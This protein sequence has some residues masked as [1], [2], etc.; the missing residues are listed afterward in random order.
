MTNLK[1]RIK[2]LKRFMVPSIP[3][4]IKTPKTNELVGLLEDLAEEVDEL[5]LRVNELLEAQL[6][7]EGEEEDVTE[8]EELQS[9]YITLLSSTPED[10]ATGV[11]STDTITLMFSGA[12]SFAHGHITVSGSSVDNEEVSLFPEGELVITLTEPIPEEGQLV[13]VTIGVDALPI[14]E[15]IVIT[16]T[17]AEAS[18]EEESEEEAV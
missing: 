17:M 7:D 3:H 9:S 10:G 5:V 1:D 4:A 14:E 6:G 11:E 18:E 16:F 2:K 13:T 8:E 15:E 12:F